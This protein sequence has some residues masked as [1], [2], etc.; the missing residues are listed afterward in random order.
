MRT[1]AEDTERKNRVCKRERKF[2]LRKLSE[3]LCKT[4]EETV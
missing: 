2:E 4:V 1:S 3:T